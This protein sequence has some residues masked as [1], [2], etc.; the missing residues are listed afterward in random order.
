MHTLDILHAALCARNLV[1]NAVRHAAS[2]T[3]PCQR[4][5]RYV[6]RTRAMYVDPMWQAVGVRLIARLIQMTHGPC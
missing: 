2:A 3:G 4:V 6:G 1:L 5:H